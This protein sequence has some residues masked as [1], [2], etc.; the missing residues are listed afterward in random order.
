MAQILNHD[1]QVLY[2]IIRK[3][4][5]LLILF[6]LNIALLYLFLKLIDPF[7]GLI[8]LLFLSL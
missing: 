5:N 7:S 3:A 4:Q 6:H 1:F 2:M 8:Q